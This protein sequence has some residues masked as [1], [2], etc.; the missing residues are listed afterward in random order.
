MRI[1][2]AKPESDPENR[3]RK[4]HAWSEA[5]NL[6]CEHVSRSSIVQIPRHPSHPYPLQSILYSIARS[7]SLALHLSAICPPSVHRPSN[8][9][10]DCPSRKRE[11]E[12]PPSPPP[13]PAPSHHEQLVLHSILA[14]QPSLYISRHSSTMGLKGMRDQDRAHYKRTLS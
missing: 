9:P 10:P 3:D 4:G 8:H 12:R 2:V 13:A 7:R 6:Q 5:R 1:E 11:R 14:P